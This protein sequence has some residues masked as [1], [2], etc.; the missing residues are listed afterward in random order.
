MWVQV[1]LLPYRG[2][3]PILHW[4]EE[5]SV[6]ED[7][8]QQINEEMWRDS[9][10]AWPRWLQHNASRLQELLHP[11]E[12]FLYLDEELGVGDRYDI[13]F[14]SNLLGYAR[15]ATWGTNIYTVV[16]KADVQ[17]E[18]HEGEAL[19]ADWFESLLEQGVMDVLEINGEFSS[20]KLKNAAALSRRRRKILYSLPSDR[21]W[22][23]YVFEP[24]LYKVGVH[25]RF[26]SSFIADNATPKG[27]HCVLVLTRPLLPDQVE[28]IKETLK[29]Q[30]QRK[31][32][33]VVLEGESDDGSSDQLYLELQTA[34][35]GQCELIACGGLFEL[36]YLLQKMNA[37]LRG[38]RQLNWAEQLTYREQSEN[39]WSDQSVDLLITHSFVADMDFEYCHAAAVE[40]H[41]IRESALNLSAAR[42][43]LYPAITTEVLPQLLEVLGTSRKLIWLH[44]GHGK[45]S[46]GIQ[47][48]NSEMFKQPEDW[49]KCFTAYK[50][51]LVMVSF[52]V[53]ESESAARYFAKQPLGVT[54]QRAYAS[55]GFGKEVPISASRFLTGKVIPIA[56]QTN[57]DK[58]AIRQAFEE[59]RKLLEKEYKETYPTL[60]MF[61]E[62]SL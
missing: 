7:G 19:R 33:V 54:Q 16:N 40:I 11:L 56:V 20:Q 62:Q 46:Q 3:Q 41:N 52:S 6:K 23:C 59:G 36:H 42:L 43:V 39:Q 48:S 58:Q 18:L 1:Y 28:F 32:L 21:P 8:R 10:A 9:S 4:V 2:A 53:C 61:E 15:K 60:F 5:N 24:S 25:K 55:I 37:P 30:R 50:G 38:A 49:L 22:R 47:E 17:Q 26:L 45:V 57:A 44:I 29:N 27:C 14:L 31:F 35:R 12:V 13:S 51:Q 34:C